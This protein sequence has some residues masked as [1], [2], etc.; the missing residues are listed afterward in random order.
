MRDDD[1]VFFGVDEF[2]DCGADVRDVVK[3]GRVARGGG[4]SAQEL[5]GF[6]G[7]AGGLEE[8]GD[9][10]EGSGADPEAGDEKDCR[11]HCWERG[12]GL[13]FGDGGDSGLLSCVEKDA[14]QAC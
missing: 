7:E 1:D 8:G 14:D 10:V 6:G 11:G 13:F 2:C 9:G 4:A 3:H 12:F 5:G